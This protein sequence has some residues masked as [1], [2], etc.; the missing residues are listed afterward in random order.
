MKKLVL[1][2]LAGFLFNSHYLFADSN[3]TVYTG[4]TIP[5]GDF[6]KTSSDDKSGYAKGSFCFG[7]E[8]SFPLNNKGFSALLSAFY[9]YN[10]TKTSDAAKDLKD[11]LLQL[12]GANYCT[13]KIDQDPWVNIPLMGGI[14]YTSPLSETSSIYTIGMAGLNI[15][16]MGDYDNKVNVQGT[17]GSYYSIDYE[18]DMTQK[19]TFNKK[20]TF[21][22]G[23]GFGINTDNLNLGV[24][25]IY[26][27]Q[28]E[29]EGKNSISTRWYDDLDGTSYSNDTDTLKLQ[30]SISLFQLLIGIN[31]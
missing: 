26:L 18:S 19:I 20:T 13:V 5:V 9:I 29:F 1:F 8:K 2:L 7:L 16:S 4:Y 14:K 30:K 25:Y 3:V 23:A 6:G 15:S 17:I 28:P 21:C 12:D 27:G 22:F 10:K 31:F 11:G 24:R